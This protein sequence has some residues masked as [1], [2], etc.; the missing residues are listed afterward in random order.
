MLTSRHLNQTW[1]DTYRLRVLDLLERMQQL[2]WGLDANS[3]ASPGMNRAFGACRKEV[4]WNRFGHPGTV[5]DHGWGAKFI[6]Q[7]PPVASTHDGRT[8]SE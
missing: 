7:Y 8:N 1:P 4:R 6:L 3:A 5:P 2:K